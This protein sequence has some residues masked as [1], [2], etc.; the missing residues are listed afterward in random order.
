M[1]PHDHISWHCLK[2]YKAHEKLKTSVGN[3]TYF[4]RLDPDCFL[5]ATWRKCTPYEYFQARN[6][7]WFGG[8]LQ[9]K[10]TITFHGE[11]DSQEL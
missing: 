11:A 2:E 9:S 8:L 1:N 7:G 10:A 5:G 6:K 3:I 4:I